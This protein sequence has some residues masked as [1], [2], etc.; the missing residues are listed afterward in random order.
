MSYEN[1]IS[2]QDFDEDALKFSLNASIL[3]KKNRAEL[4]EMVNDKTNDL[5]NLNEII[6]KNIKYRLIVKSMKQKTLMA[7]PLS[8]IASEDLTTKE[9]LQ[10]YLDNTIEQLILNNI[11]TK[12]FSY[13]EKVAALLEVNKTPQ[14]LYEM[15]TLKAD[16]YTNDPSNYTLMMIS[17]LYSLAA[18]VKENSS[19]ENLLNLLDD[20]LAQKVRDSFVEI[21]NTAINKNNH[22]ILEEY[23]SLVFTKNLSSN[24]PVEK[25]M[26][27]LIIKAATFEFK[28]MAIHYSGIGTLKIE[29]NKYNDCFN[30]LRDFQKKKALKDK[31]DRYK[32]ETLVTLLYQLN[33]TIKTQQQNLTEDSVVEFLLD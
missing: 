7:T 6:R 9:K 26:L 8:E 11:S 31:F 27:D 24:S 23:A 12:Y 29:F 13:V 25:A 5:F 17:S 30:N 16:E 3:Y 32:H 2:H 21:S 20:S 19:L 33:L 10:N 18:I 28:K 1:Y 4:E 15:A 22:V 14:E